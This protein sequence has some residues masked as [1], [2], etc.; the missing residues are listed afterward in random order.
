MKKL[1][2]ISLLTSTLF[3]EHKELVSDFNF[4]KDIKEKTNESAFGKTSTYSL[5]FARHE[6]TMEQKNLHFYY[7]AKLGVVSEEFNSDN[8]FGLPLSEMGTYF[9]AAVGMEYDLNDQAIL[10]AEGTRSE[11]HLNKLTESKVKLTYTYT[12]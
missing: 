5:L 12:Y 4:V 2:L 9:A 7:G 1:I 3:A 6:L 10:M 8:G 11:D